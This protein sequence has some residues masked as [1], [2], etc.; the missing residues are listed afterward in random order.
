[1]W[2][3]APRP[4]GLWIPKHDGQATSLRDSIHTYPPICGVYSAAGG[5]SSALPEH[6]VLRHCGKGVSSHCRG[7]ASSAR[8]PYHGAALAEGNLAQSPRG[9]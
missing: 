2:P 6:P 4:M 1:M 8:I 7:S 9:R 3:L 5:T